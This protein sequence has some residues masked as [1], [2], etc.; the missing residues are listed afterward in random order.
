MRAKGYK[1]RTPDAATSKR[2]KGNNLMSLLYH[3]KIEKSIGEIKNH[4]K[5]NALEKA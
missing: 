2:S 4:G 3:K 1:K 5:I